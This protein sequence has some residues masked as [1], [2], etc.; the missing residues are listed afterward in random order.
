MTE[1][2]K[3]TIGVQEVDDWCKEGGAD[4]AR[5]NNNQCSMGGRLV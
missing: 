5:K 3:I 2:G 1:R 4:D